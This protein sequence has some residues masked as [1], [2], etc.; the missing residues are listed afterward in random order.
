M[1]KEKIEGMKKKISEEK[2]ED[3]QLQLYMSYVYQKE[4]LEQK[5]EKEILNQEIP[6][7]MQMKDDV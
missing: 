3:K 6:P 2:N 4:R 7:E 5:M 1:V